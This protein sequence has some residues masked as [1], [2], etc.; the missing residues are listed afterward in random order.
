M[1]KEAFVAFVK[2]CGWEED[3]FGHLHRD[4]QNGRKYRLKI[5]ATSFRYEVQ[6]VIPG[7]TYTT[8]K[9]EW[10]RVAGDYYKNVQEKEDMVT[11]GSGLAFRK[12]Q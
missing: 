6:T 12:R 7:G 2:L 9:K 5:Q 1:K 4:G 11:F 10:V 3:R 8:E